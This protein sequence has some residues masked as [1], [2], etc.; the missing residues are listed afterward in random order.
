MRWSE[1]MSSDGKA[2]ICG[3]AKKM[4][5]CCMYSDFP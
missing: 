3:P 5:V 4:S 1:Y 2:A